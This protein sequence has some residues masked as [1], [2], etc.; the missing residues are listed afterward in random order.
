MPKK[1]YPGVNPS[2]KTISKMGGLH[3]SCFV[4]DV[5]SGE[6]LSNTQ[7]AVVEEHLQAHLNKIVNLMP[8]VEKAEVIHPER[9]DPLV[10]E[11]LRLK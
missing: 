1:P 10:L 5:L 2:I 11:G 7:Q 4:I 9:F 8:A 6:K 3:R